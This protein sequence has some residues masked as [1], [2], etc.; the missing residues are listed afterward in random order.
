MQEYHQR[1]NH[2]LRFLVKEYAWT[3]DIGTV[4]H[5][6]EACVGYLTRYPQSEIT[7]TITVARLDL[8]SDYDYSPLMLA[9]ENWRHMNMKAEVFPP[10]Y[11]VHTSITHTSLQPAD[12]IV[13]SF[14]VRINSVK[15]FHY[16]LSHFACVR[17]R[18]NLMLMLCKSK[19]I[20]HNRQW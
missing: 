3:L 7:I 19:I 1:W 20:F 2:W 6:T 4:V 8:I 17:S 13:N 11:P 18:P 12:C 5:N 10:E 15:K 16:Q 9:T 14:D